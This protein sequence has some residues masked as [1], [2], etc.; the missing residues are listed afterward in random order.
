MRLRRRENEP[1][2]AGV[3]AEPPASTERFSWRKIWFV[4]AVAAATF[5]A[6]SLISAATSPTA[7]SE[8]GEYRVQQVEIPGYGRQVA[9]WNP[10]GGP[11]T[12]RLNLTAV[13][14]PA[15]RK[16]A[17]S[18]TRQ[19]V[20]RIS[21][22]T[23]LQFTYEGQTTFIPQ[24]D[25]VGPAQVVIAFVDPGQTSYDLSGEVAGYGGGNVIWSRKTEKSP[26]DVRRSSGFVVIDHVQTQH[27]N[28]SSTAPGV[29][30]MNLL[31]HELGH[32]VG[33]EH[34]KDPSQLMNPDLT[35]KTPGGHFGDGDMVALKAVGPTGRCDRK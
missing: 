12:W 21:A 28:R 35:D 11:I 18:E 17:A 19:A 22:A 6:T 13:L 34:V 1:N 8:P 26:W 27:W 10:C 15:E 31:V 29:T 25:K 30:R 23:G 7:G 5:A 2:P 33:L 4:P 32:V 3:F 9:T 14:D 20:D 16:A 24:P